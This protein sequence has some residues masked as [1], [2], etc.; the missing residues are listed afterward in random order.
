MSGPR[1]SRYSPHLVAPADLERLFV[2][3]DDLLA[4]LV[5]DVRDSVADGSGRY[6]LIV[7]P[8]GA[9]KSHLSALLRARLSAALGETAVL[10][11]LDEE[12]N[13]GSLVD[14]LARV[15]RKFPVESALPSAQTQLQALRRLPHHEAEERAVGLME[16]RLRERAFV[17]SLENTDQIFDDLGRD[18]QQRLRTV[19][20]AHPHWSVVATSRTLG[21]A[22]L[23]PQSPF[24]NTFAV[25]T[26]APLDPVGCRDLLARLADMDGRD[27][28]A[29]FLRTST[30]LARVRAIHHFA[31]GNPRAMALLHPYL[32]QE[33]LGELIGAFYDLSD[34]LTPYFREQMARLPSGQRPILEALAENWRPMSPSELADAL[35]QTPATVSVQLKRLREDRL[36][37]AMSVGRERF[38]EIAEPLHRLA[39]AMKR[40]D[41]AGEAFARFLRHWHAM[42]EMEGLSADNLVANGRDALP[43]DPQGPEGF[44]GT[45]ADGSRMPLLA[46]DVAGSSTMK[47]TV[48]NNL[49]AVLG[50]IEAALGHEPSITS[51]IRA[52]PHDTTQYARLAEAERRAVQDVLGR[53]GAS[54]TLAALPA[55]A[56]FD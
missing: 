28:L 54:D 43:S 4:R 25:H 42:S 41:G 18:G 37:V 55:E 6:V 1:H 45:L 32:T 50:R 34:E 48:R 16:A 31:G 14:L 11:A 19:L 26:L 20:Q 5:N 10:V 15:L 30:G 2:G 51:A 35:F 13:V 9:G 12:E 46:A 39:W 22:F 24:F 47:V 3:R 49:L 27:D 21:P 44:L 36:V 7:G 56:C 38:Y 23:R 17:L 53:F 52:L 33:R 40:R 8:R 29:E